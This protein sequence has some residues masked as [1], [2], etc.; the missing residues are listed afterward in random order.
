M[1]LATAILKNLLLPKLEKDSLFEVSKITES[2]L[3]S[4]VTALCD[5]END[6]KPVYAL[7]YRLELKDTEKII[8]KLD[9]IYTDF[10]KELAENYIL[11]HSSEISNLLL[12]SKNATFEKE[13]SFFINL[14][15]AIKKTER[16][17]IKQELPSAYDKLVFEL[18]EKTLEA[19]TKKKVREDLRKKF[20]QWDKE[21]VEEESTPVLSMLIDENK[22]AKPTTVISLS[23]IKYAAAAT[24]ILFVG[25]FYFNK[26]QNR[27]ETVIVK[28]EE[29][30]PAPA[31]TDIITAIPN[32]TLAEISTVSKSVNINESTGLGFATKIKK[33]SLI[34]NNQQARINSI[35]KAIDK[36]RKDLEKEFATN[37]VGDTPMIKELN[38]RID[39]LQNEL[40]LLKDRERQYLF[41][42]KVL[43]LYVS[44]ASNENQVLLYQDNYYLKKETVFYTLKIAKQLQAYKK[45]SDSA[46]VTELDKILFDNGY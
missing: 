40:N 2:F 23:W 37:Q 34:E 5:F 42:G 43:T 19:V 29:K 10:I 9:A 15:K 26:Q 11:G 27:N 16:N 28:S 32:E 14:E 44:K 45:V 33:I 39:K 8:S 22:K 18:D 38:S 4:F 20:K 1:K 36:Y 31:K 17:R 41:D 6:A 25:L 3:E 30:K 24:I 12:A 35:N 7:L 21:F 46:L 13:V